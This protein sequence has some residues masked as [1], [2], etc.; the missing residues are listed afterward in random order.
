[1]TPK[2]P[3]LLNRVDPVYKAT[4]MHFQDLM[5]RYGGPIVVLDLVKQSEKREREVIVGNEYRH[6]IEYL[7][8]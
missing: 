7:N 1:M 5:E 2:P 3:I 6:A 4:R 8:R